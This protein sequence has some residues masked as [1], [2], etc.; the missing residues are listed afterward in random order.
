VRIELKVT[1]FVRDCFV[2][3]DSGTSDVPPLRVLA[4][5]IIKKMMENEQ[6][7]SCSAPR[8]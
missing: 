3:F 6:N 1:F 8:I 2:P 5:T 7:Q 4:M